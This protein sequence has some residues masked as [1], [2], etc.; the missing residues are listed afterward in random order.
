MKI[1]ILNIAS[2]RNG[3]AGAPFYA[4]VFRDTGEL[5]SIKLGIVFHEP[6]HTAVLDIAKLNN[7]DIKFGSN[8]WRGDQYEPALRQA[9]ADREKLNESEI[10][11]TTEYTAEIDVC[12]YLAERHEIAHIWGIEDVKELRPDLSDEQAWEVL[13][14]VEDNLDSNCGINWQRLEDTAED[15]FGSNTKET[16]PCK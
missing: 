16:S 10:S 7:R 4:I 6:W 12:A 2:H 5:G 1:R 9:I 3:I 14:T 15:M 11:G 8:S 13:V